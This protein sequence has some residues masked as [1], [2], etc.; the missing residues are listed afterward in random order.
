MNDRAGFLFGFSRLSR[1]RRN[2][3]KQNEWH[4]LNDQNPHASPR[5]AVTYSNSALA[6]LEGLVQRTF[7]RDKIV[8]GS[9]LA[10]YSR[11]FES[12]VVVFNFEL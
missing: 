5:R 11:G 2:E 10:I 9:H 12:H 6:E 8:R 7:S 1:G 3:K 4:D